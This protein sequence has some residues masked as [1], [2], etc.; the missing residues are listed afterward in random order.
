MLPLE[1]LP[2]SKELYPN[3][4]DVGGAREEIGKKTLQK[5]RELSISLKLVI[6]FIQKEREK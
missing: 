4:K 1:L 5:L 2:Q 6:R 3:N